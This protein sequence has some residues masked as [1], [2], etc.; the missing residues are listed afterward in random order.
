M[1]W[2]R[3]LARLGAA[4]DAVFAEL[5]SYQPMRAGSIAGETADAARPALA[6]P[7]VFCRSL[8]G[9]DAGRLPKDR[10]GAGRADNFGMT[11]LVG[12]ARF[13]ASTSYFNG[14]APMAGDRL[15]RGD[16]SHWRVAA[17]LPDADRYILGLTSA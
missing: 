16:G 6:L 3:Q 14:R 17:V 2:A 1:S 15:T 9:A 13:S 12:E 11:A 8:A 4:G 5:V 10:R 7:G